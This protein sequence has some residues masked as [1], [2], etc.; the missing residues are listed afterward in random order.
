[1]EYDIES[2]LM[3][4]EIAKGEISHAVEFGNFII[5]LSKQSKPILIEILDAS[6]FVG[7]FDKLKNTKEFKQAYAN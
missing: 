3:S 6:K 7:Q 5:H 2:N 4:I 1:M